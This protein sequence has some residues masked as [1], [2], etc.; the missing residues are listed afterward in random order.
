MKDLKLIIYL[1]ASLILL[2]V[3]ACEEDETAPV[4]VN[5]S[6]TE[7]GIS[8]EASSADIEISFSR[9]AESDGNLSVQIKS[10]SLA[11]G[12]DADFFTSPA[13]SDMIATVP[14]A[15]G[16]E[17]VTVT[18]SAGSALNIDQDES[19]TL[20][21]SNDTGVLDLGDQ[22]T[23][24]V[25]FSE[26]FVVPSAEIKTDVGGDDRTHQVYI[27][28]SSGQTTRV[29]RNDFDLV[30][31]SA[32]D[33]FN[34][35]LNATAVMNAK[36][37]DQI[38]FTKVSEDDTVGLDLSGLI[39][40]AEEGTTFT[41][42]FAETVFYEWDKESTTSHVYIIDRGIDKYGGQD[43]GWKKVQITKSG[44]SYTVRSADLDGTNETSFSINKSSNQNFKYVHFGNGEA[45]VAPEDGQW[46]LVLSTLSQVAFY[47]G[48]YYGTY[49]SQAAFHNFYGGTLVAV[50][51]TDEV[52]ITYEDLTKEAAISALSETEDDYSIIGTNWRGLDANYQI[53]INS[54]LIYCFQDIDGNLFKFQFTAYYNGDSEVGPSFKYEHLK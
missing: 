43:R 3:T 40:R 39:D 16:D 54:N 15:I 22:V 25:V 27:D 17:S 42:D 52:E 34:I 53:V 9:P 51:N 23:F 1:L 19:I 12:E 35:L 26:N 45:T 24:T 7:T 28:L 4:R 13:A 18:I 46:D 10:A 29:D 33:G 44:T 21:I 38:D 14:F 2:G 47:G 36:K 41:G 50:I 8:D 20:T 31:E 6:N 37:T 5:F 11:Y 30:L 32:G 49:N 48:Q